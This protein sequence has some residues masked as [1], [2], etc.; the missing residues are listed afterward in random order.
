M[1]CCLWMASDSY[2]GESLLTTLLLWVLAFGWWTFDG[3]G[4]AEWSVRKQKKS[5]KNELI[6]I[7]EYETQIIGPVNGKLEAVICLLIKWKNGIRLIG[8]GILI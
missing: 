5:T 1:V 3:L 2:A 4:N 8:I 7:V 6:V